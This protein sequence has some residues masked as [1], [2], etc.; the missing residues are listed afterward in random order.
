[1]WIYKELEN[2]FCSFLHFLFLTAVIF[3][4][5]C[6]FSVP[7]PS[8]G[9]V[10]VPYNWRNMRWLS[11]TY[12][13]RF[14]IL[15]RKVDFAWANEHSAWENQVFLFDFSL[16]FVSLQSNILHYYCLGG[17]LLKTPI[18]IYFK[19]SLEWESLSRDRLSFC[20]C[21]YPEPWRHVPQRMTECTTK[22]GW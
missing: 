20:T 11:A 14:Y 6:I 9:I 10:S 21:L 8:L 3:A 13:C 12:I 19:L 16:L 18:I 4:D 5:F 2:R 1:M 15:R 17:R 7:P 22:Y